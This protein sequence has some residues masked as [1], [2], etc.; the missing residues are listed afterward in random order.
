MPQALEQYQRLTGRQPKELFADRGYRGPKTINETTIHTPKPD[1]KITPQKRK[2]HRRRA[3]IEPTIGHL[4]SDYRMVRNYLKGA[5][6]DDINVMLA[7][8]AMNFKRVMN[9]WKRRQIQFLETILITTIICLR[10]CLCLNRK[11]TF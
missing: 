7:A 4:K 2:K 5:I 3:A 11:L 1:N 10:N 6:G 8:A 9:L